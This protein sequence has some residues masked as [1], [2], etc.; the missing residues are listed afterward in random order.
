MPTRLPGSPMLAS[1]R[2]V[3]IRYELDGQAYVGSGLRVGAR[4]VLTADH[5][6][7]GAHHRVLCGGEE[8]DATVS[9]RSRSLHV[10]VAVLEVP[11]APE[12]EPLG[13]ARVNR[14]IAASV[15]DCQALGFPRWKTSNGRIL[16]QLDGFVPT[17]E[18]LMAATDLGQ[19]VEYLTLK[20]TGPAIADDRLIPT[21]NLEAAGSPWAGMSGAVVVV[22]NLVIGVVRS[23]NLAEGGGSLTV[24]PIGAIDQLR[25]DVRDR[26]WRA[27]GVL[28]STALP[29][30]PEV[31]Q[32]DVLSEMFPFELLDHESVV[33]GRVSREQLVPAMSEYLA[34]EIDPGTIA[35]DAEARLNEGSVL[36]LGSGS[37]GKTTLAVWIGLR[38][39]SDGGQCFYLDL[40]TVDS[41]EALQLIP[42]LLSILTNFATA[43]TLFIVDNV[44]QN[45]EIAAA[46]LR[47]WNRIGSLGKF[48]LVGRR[49][50]GSDYPRHDHHLPFLVEHVTSLEVDANDL[51]HTC[52]RIAARYSAGTIITLPQDA[53]QSWLRLFGGDRVAFGIAV[54][55]HLERE[56]LQRWLMRGALLQPEDAI[57]YTREQYLDR[58]PEAKEDLIKLA[59]GSSMEVSLPEEAVDSQPLDRAIASGLVLR[60][61]HGTQAH[62]RYGLVHPGL[63]WLLLS[64]AR[65]RDTAAVL[66]VIAEDSP[67]TGFLLAARLEAAGKVYDAV[68]VLTSICRDANSLV[69]G[70]HPSTIAS[71][72]DRLQRLGIL[73]LAD[74]DEILVESGQRYRILQDI[75]DYPIGAILA[76][77]KSAS[78]WLPRLFESLLPE[79]GEPARVTRL[80]DAGASALSLDD[81]AAFLVQVAA[82]R[83]DLAEKIITALGEPARVTRLADAGASALNLGQTAAFLVQVAARWPDLAE[84]IITALGEP[85]RVTRLADAGASALNLGDVA[86]FL[87]QVAARWP[88]LAE[89]IITALGEPAR[90]TRLANAGASALNL[91]DVAAFLV[92]VAARWPDLAQEFATA[93]G[94]PARV[95]RLADAARQRTEPGRRGGVPGPGRRP[96]A[97][98]GR[99]NHHRAGRARPGDP[100][101]R[102]RRQRT[103]PGR[104]GGVPGPG[105]RPVAGPGP[106]FAT[107]LGEPARVTRLADAGASAQDLSQ[108]AAFLVQVAARR[109]DLA[110]KIITAL[111]EPARVTRLADAGAS[112][113]DLGQT[114]AFL[115]QVAARWPDLA[116]KI[117]TALG[118]PARVTRLAN[119]LVAAP[120][121]AA[122]RFLRSC[123]DVMPTVFD[124]LI[125]SVGKADRIEQLAQLIAG[126]LRH[127]GWLLETVQSYPALAR[128]IGQR[129]IHAESINKLAG[130]PAPNF[131]F[132]RSARS[133]IVVAERLN[134]A[135]EEGK[136]L[137][138]TKSLLSAFQQG[139]HL[140]GSAHLRE[141]A[142]TISLARASGFDLEKQIEWA[143]A[144]TGRSRY[145]LER[146]FLTTH[147]GSLADSL[148]QLWWNCCSPLPVLQTLCGSNLDS[149]I[150][151]EFALLDIVKLTNES[152]RDPL[153]LAGAIGKYRL[154]P[155]PG[156][157]NLE[158]RDNGECLSDLIGNLVDVKMR[159]QVWAG[160]YVIRENSL[161]D[162]IVSVAAPLACI[163][164]QSVT[165][166]QQRPDQ[167]LFRAEM[168]AW[169]GRLTG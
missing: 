53:A 42:R 84:K 129:L 7:A 113:Q 77:V 73:P 37:V 81:V 145:W 95:T 106:E 75:L 109:P 79:L 16:V 71:N 97:G 60:T 74:A 131:N 3:L 6:A 104:R 32:P 150:A 169:L 130:A 28:D 83:P 135:G 123:H 46:L 102:R 140:D 48:L 39:S 1:E 30:L 126:D 51:L 54:R 107:A 38:H 141:L 116:E 68:Q 110:E 15:Q 111:G 66:Q 157:I 8:L 91:G 11:S 115:V 154:S 89:K 25:Q 151:D 92:Q 9:V 44:H 65:V 86:A 153:R 61:T 139:Y 34:G 147:C 122:F 149:R 166:L 69:A 76:F 160:L 132:T 121:R 133:L 58:W 33:F 117:I 159:M 161:V 20:A 134:E 148:D 14:T 63:G 108:T 23:H 52:S 64:A 168:L 112:G 24:T 80:A 93:L 49:T 164:W 57:A 13:F 156:H 27:L 67:F 143:L 165:I 50:F 103:E 87:V 162:E 56:G 35:I 100:P 43:S 90:V 152:L 29:T 98:P 125:E 17:A 2:A 105:R 47:H 45:E 21:G 127:S 138:L 40:A 26:M 12:V 55:H 158:I 146:E 19:R 94:E 82:R 137:Q 142:K 120:P 85:A 128:N 59:V 124:Q 155:S 41:N 163:D 88:D 5:C 72:L 96:V 10:D 78:L 118:E 62:R 70:L 99:E 31:G 136:A 36:L 114:A 144:A 167:L 4:F 18:G 119:A 101:G 22:G